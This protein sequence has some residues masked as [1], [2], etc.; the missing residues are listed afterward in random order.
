IGALT[1]TAGANTGTLILGDASVLDGAVGGAVGLRAINVV[2]GSNAAGVT[3][4][5]TGAA[6]A[7]TFNLGTNTLNVGGALNIANGGPNGVI[8]TTLASPT[9]FGNIRP[10]GATTLGPTLLVNVLVPSTAFIPVGTQF[11]IVQT[12]T[13]TL[14][15]GTNGSVVAVTVQNP[16]NPLY[17]FSAVPAAGTIAGLVTIQTTG[18]PLLVPLN[19]PPGAVLPPVT[20][21]AAAVAQAI[22]AAPPSVAAA[23]NAFSDPASVVNALAQ[24]APSAP[25]L[26]APLVTYQ[27]TREF[28]NLWMARLDERLCGDVRRPDAQ[29]A[30]CPRNEKG[31]GWWVKGFG[32]FGDQDARDTFVGY[33]SR[34]GGAMIAYDTL[35][36]P[37][38]RAGFGVGYSRSAI[39]GKTFDASTDIDTYRA[40]AYIGHE[41]GPWFIYGDASFGWNQ[42]SGTRHVA[43]TGVDRTANADY[44]GQEYT[45]T[46]TTGY[47]FFT[48][49]RVVVTPLASLQYTHLNLRGYTETG[50]G[51]INL[52]VDSQSYDFLESGLGV[53]VERAF[54]HGNATY[55][56]EVHF[57]WFHQLSNPTLKNTAAFTTAGSPA[58]TTPGLRTDDN[59]FN[60]GTS[61]TL[62]SCA[63][64]AKTWS[65]EAGYDYDWRTDN[66]SAHR[67][68]IKFASRF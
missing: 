19:P 49:D 34:T 27:V 39:D 36:R 40:T 26:A 25:D 6:N 18:I 68:M 23:L 10:V 55:V 28:Q 54:A 22:L 35:L 37:D 45:G 47:H 16:T 3:A 61:L 44:K 20:P 2:G 8:N 59:T 17:T 11:N 43:F 56:P 1:T 24:L 58:F 32:Y 51:D 29:N 46:V 12:Q 9:V 30:T 62:L 21:I 13:G 15:S 41:S 52:R 5:I 42:Y 67:A 14:Q 65:L 64:A 63:C 38:T 48:A 66:Y 33:R 50:A 4:T 7:V 60:I 53:K 31:N 57:K